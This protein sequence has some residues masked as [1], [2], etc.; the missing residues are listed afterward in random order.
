MPTHHVDVTGRP[1]PI[2]DRAPAT[3]SPVWFEV[4]PSLK[5]SAVLSSDILAALGM[6]VAFRDG[7]DFGTMSAPGAIPLK[8]D[9][10]YHRALVELNEQGTKAAAATAVAMGEV[11]SLRVGPPPPVPTFTA[12]HPFLFF[13]RDTQTGAI[14]FA[15]RVTDPS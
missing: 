2:S 1:T 8:I 11:T 6:G 7:A 15:G 5:R 4:R 3:G 10:V 13:L 14:L 12:D 9:Q